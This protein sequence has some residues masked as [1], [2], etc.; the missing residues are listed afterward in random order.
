MVV[1][2]HGDNASQPRWKNLL[3]FLA[4]TS[5]LAGALWWVVTK[6]ITESIIAFCAPWLIVGILGIISLIFFVIPM[7]PFMLILRKQGK[8]KEK[9]E[10]KV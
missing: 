9:Q 1:A 4:V 6:N 10:G 8:R 5:M 3:V 7:I 2:V